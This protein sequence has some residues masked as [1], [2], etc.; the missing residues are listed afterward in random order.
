VKLVCRVFGHRFRSPF[1]EGDFRYCTRC[2]EWE[3]T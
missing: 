2:G 3:E 1:I